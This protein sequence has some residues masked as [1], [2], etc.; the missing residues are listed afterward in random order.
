MDSTLTLLRRLTE[1]RVEFVIVGGMASTLH[2]SRLLTQDVDV[3]VPFDRENVTKIL[4]ALSEL[5]PKQRMRPDRSPL[6]TDP[7]TYEGWRNLYVV[8]DSARSAHS[9]GRKTFAPSRNSSSSGSGSV[10]SS[11]QRVARAASRSTSN[12]SGPK[13]WRFDSPSRARTCAGVSMYPR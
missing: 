3:R 9:G 5:N 11:R 12:S 7:A 6:S 4:A 1:Q 2:G 10:G 13:Y 8:T